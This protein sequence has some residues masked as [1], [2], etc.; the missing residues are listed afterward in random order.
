MDLSLEELLIALT[1]ASQCQ[2]H[3]EGQITEPVCCLHQEETQWLIAFL[4]LILILL[5]SDWSSVFWCCYCGGN[6][7]IVL[8]IKSECLI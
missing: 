2:C 3:L 7:L 1:H 8:F 6:L 5:L 4:I